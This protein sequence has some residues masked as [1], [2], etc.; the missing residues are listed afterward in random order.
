MYF[1]AATINQKTTVPPPINPSI[2]KTTPFPLIN[3]SGEIAYN[4]EAFFGH[5]KKLSDI[6]KNILNMFSFRNIF[7][8]YILCPNTAVF[9]TQKAIVETVE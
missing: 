1:F 8:K 4:N 5:S 2:G 6:M 9:F 3:I 7:N